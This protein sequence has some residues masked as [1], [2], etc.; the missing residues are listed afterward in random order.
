MAD[1][2]TALITGASRGIGV[3]LARAFAARGH[4]LVLTARD[5]AAL[6]ALAGELT[7]STGVEVATVACDLGAAEGPAALAAAIAAQGLRVDVL[8]NNAG[9]GD[10][11]PFAGSERATQLGMIDLN[12]R[13]LVELTHIYWPGIL[14]A[15]ARGGLLNVASTSAFQPGPMMSIYFAT[16]A[17][18]LSFTEALWEEARGTGARVSCL[19][20]GP[21]ESAFRLRAGTDRPRLADAGKPMR[22]NE[23]AE[24]AYAG[25]AA[26]RRVVVPGARN[27]AMATLAPLLP[28]PLVLRAVRA[29]MAPRG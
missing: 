17:F 14:A 18:V 29:L 12:V 23:V 7:R 25:F 22:A 5:G 26:N 9:F 10:T 16:K 3:E 8:V 15:G 20:P 1:R 2:P 28:R 19:C 27:K 4:D 6:A 24:Q 11:G 13:A 21:T